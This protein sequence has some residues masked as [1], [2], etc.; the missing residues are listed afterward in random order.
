MGGGRV[1]DVAYGEREGE[2][3]EERGSERGGEMEGGRKGERERNVKYISS[4]GILL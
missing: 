4:H 2:K 1:R 3:G